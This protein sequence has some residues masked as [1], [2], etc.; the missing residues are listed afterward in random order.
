M[1]DYHMA[2]KVDELADEWGTAS[3]GFKKGM[4]TSAKLYFLAMCIIPV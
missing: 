4:W 2:E 3:W 1:L